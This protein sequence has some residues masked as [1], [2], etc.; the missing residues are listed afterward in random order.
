MGSSSIFNMEG[1]LIYN[2]K[3]KNGKDIYNNRTKIKIAENELCTWYN[4][5]GTI[6]ERYNEEIKS[7]NIMQ[8]R[9]VYN[10]TDTN[11]NTAT[12][13]IATTARKYVKNDL[14]RLN[15]LQ[16]S[17]DAVN[18]PESTPVVNTTTQNTQVTTPTTNAPTTNE[19]G[20]N[21]EETNTPATTEPAVNAETTTTPATI[22]PAVNAEVIT[23]PVTTEP[24]AN[25][26]EA[27]TPATTEPIANAEESNTSSTNT[28]ATNVEETGAEQ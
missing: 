6:F 22:E 19:Q 1:G 28:E 26:E 16:E 11:T 18:T 17:L 5:D 7:E 24:V 23:T 20:A 21:V 14:T 4:N 15:K 2:N 13:G 25:V 9:A 12:Y 8:L 10:G 27:N 3:D